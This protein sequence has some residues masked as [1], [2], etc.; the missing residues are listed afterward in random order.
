VSEPDDIEAVRRALG[1]RLASLRTAAGLSQPQLAP[2]V[3]YSRSTL[4]NAETGRRPAAREFWQRCDE[5]LAT[6]GVLGRQ[7]DELAA[8]KQKRQA[9]A[10]QA[11][12]AERLARI[13]QAQQHPLTTWQRQPAGELAAPAEL[14][15]I[16]DSWEVDQSNGLAG[17]LDEAAPSVAAP[18]LARLIHEWLV[19]EPPH[20]L[21]LQAGRQIGDRLV[22]Q[23]ERRVVQLR[24]LDDFV[25]GR[26]LHAL[27]ERELAVTGRLLRDASYTEALG[28]RLFVAIGELCQLAGWVA[29]DAGQYGRAAHY[30]ALGVKAAHAAGDRPLAAN[31]IS[32]LAYQTSN[33]GNPLDGVLLAQTASRGAEHAATATAQALFH[34]RVAWAQAKAGNRRSTEQA[35]AQVEQNFDRRRPDDD[36]EWIYWLNEDEI[37]V[38]AARCYVELGQGSRA[39][40]LL[41][42]VLDHYDEQRTREAALYTSW[43]AEAH[44]QTGDIDRAAELATKTATL[45]AHTT[46]TRSDERLNLLRAKLGPYQGVAAVSDFLAQSNE[47]AL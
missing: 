18:T 40:P 9:A 35:L 38:M 15:L 23:V 34:E 21:E 33:T 1:E 31:V 11:A 28:K 12:R 16:H 39:I 37:A 27:V 32:T 13:E 22:T 5:V 6:G 14:S 47:L 41:T 30:F 19:V 7:Y 8:R 43:L 26:D 36:P 42:D 24:H 29:A 46:S 10:Q 45:T 4:A 2:L 3:G 25:G 20:H 17:L 44:I